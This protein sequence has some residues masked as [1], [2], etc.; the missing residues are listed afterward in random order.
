MSIETTAPADVSSVANPPAAR[1][2]KW[3]GIAVAVVTMLIL[4]GSIGWWVFSLV[5]KPKS[6]EL[7]IVIDRGPAVRGFDGVHERPNGSYMARAGDVTLVVAKGKTDKDWNLS[8]MSAKPDLV[9]PEYV[10]PL[11]A[12]R[13]IASDPGWARTL[14]LTPDQVKQLKAI[15][16]GGNIILS[17]EQRQQLKTLWDAYLSASDK[18]VAE[19]ELIFQLHRIGKA[20]LAATRADVAERAKKVQAILSPEQIAQFK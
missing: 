4:L 10:P 11:Q 18:V 20:S 6:S 19:N 5:S 8:L 7:T 3:T 9:P 16:G 13:A 1:L 2:P 17:D 15:P 12:R 14:K